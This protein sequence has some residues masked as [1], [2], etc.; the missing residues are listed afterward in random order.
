MWRL[1]KTQKSIIIVIII[2]VIIITIIII[3]I[4]EN[5]NTNNNNEKRKITPCYSKIKIYIIKNF[6]SI[7]IYQNYLTNIGNIKASHNT[8]TFRCEYDIKH[9]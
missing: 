1:R 9:M 8:S 6:C 7:E 3:V 2:I 5:D 4:A